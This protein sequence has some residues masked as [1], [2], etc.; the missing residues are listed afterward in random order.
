ME[1]KQVIAR[2]NE[3]YHKSQQMNLTAEELEER[4]KLRRIYLEA[5]RGQVKASL[6]GVVPKRDQDHTC[7][8]GHPEDCDC[9]HKH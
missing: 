1:L 8:C 5:I 2:L 9:G 6:I 7:L 4:D 3:I